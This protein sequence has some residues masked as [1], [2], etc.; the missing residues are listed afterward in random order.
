[1]MRRFWQGRVLKPLRGLAG[2]GMTA[3]TLALCV[4]LG[5]VLGIF[6]VLGCPTP[7]CALA[8]LTLRL[9]LPA[10]QAFNYLVYPLQLALLVPF[11]RLGDLWFRPTGMQGLLG[12]LTAALCAAAAWFC[13]CVPLGLMLYWILA[14]LLRTPRVCTKR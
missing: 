9:N 12:V 13:V 10:I 4:A 7:F 1:M 14:C 6:P 5:L 2:Q 11:F 8:A 3:D